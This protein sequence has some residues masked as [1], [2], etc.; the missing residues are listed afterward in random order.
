MPK[1][2]QRTLDGVGRVTHIVRAMKEFAHP[3][4]NEQSAADINHALDTT[5]TVAC[6][7]YKYVARVETRFGELPEVMC[8]IGELNQ[9]F[10]NLIVNAAH[11]IA[12][13]GKDA[14]T[15]VISISTEAVGPE[16]SVSIADNGC[17]IPEKN[18]ERIFDP[19]FTTKEV[20]KGTGQGLA[21]AR[22]IVVEKHG[23]K[24]DV[25][26]EVGG[27]TRFTIRLPLGG[28]VAGTTA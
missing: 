20:G 6:N 27:G 26:S 25:R 13:S 17:G 3:A 5:L 18:R 19:F 9:V 24:I 7:E 10:L 28:Q 12:Q 15:G 11:A 21:I 16:I 8:N 23:G 4:S 2:F 1:A 22:S 14:S